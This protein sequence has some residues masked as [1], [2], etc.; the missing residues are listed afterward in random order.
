MLGL[1]VLFGWAFDVTPLKSVLPGLIAMQPWAAITIALA[2]GAL[3]VATVPGRIAAATSLAL[4]GAVLLSGLQML[5]QHVTG[6]DFGTDRWF[7]PEV[8][9]N[10]PLN[11]HPGRVAEVT[12][13]AFALL[14]AMLLL[15]RVERAWAR[16]V[17]STIGTVGLLLMAAPLLGYLIGI[18]T[19]QS[20]AFVTPIAL[21]AAF[22]L[23]VL[24]LGTLALRP[25]TGWMAL[26][27]GDRPGAATA[28]MLLPV[29]VIGPLLLA[30]LFEA[31]RNAGLYGSEFRLALT[32]LA[33]VALLATSLLWSAAR[34]DRLHRARLAAAEA[35][36]RSEERYRTLVEGQ[37]DPI[38]QFLPDTTLTFVNRAYADFYGQE[39][40]DLVGRRWLDFARQGRAAAVPRRV[41]VVH[42]RTSGAARGNPQHPSRP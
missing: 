5:L 30:F 1:T 4:A 31:G 40:E 14:G 32:T 10:Q 8:V 35:L 29:V 16:G 21:H 42:A 33:T 23:V 17:F 36:R 3:L 26:L 20:V 7:F 15:A 38:C 11:P 13:I 27:S 19:L 22:G 9:A 28:R 12:S 6:F 25:D 2:G 24:F 34:V 39:P 37:P 18:G 41:D